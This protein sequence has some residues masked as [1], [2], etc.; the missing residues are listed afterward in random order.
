MK[1]PSQTDSRMYMYSEVYSAA[2]VSLEAT[3]II[4][5]SSVHAPS[6]SPLTFRPYILLGW[7]TGIHLI[8]KMLF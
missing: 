6:Y 2:L 5:W 3:S 8:M 1:D 4:D 7:R